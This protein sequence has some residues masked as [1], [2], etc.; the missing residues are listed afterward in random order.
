MMFAGGAS[1]RVRNPSQ[2]LEFPDSRRSSLQ[3][4]HP[5]AY[6]LVGVAS[7]ITPA[8]LHVQ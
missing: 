1:C 4:I 6:G 5:F 7:T 3:Q 2:C 8:L